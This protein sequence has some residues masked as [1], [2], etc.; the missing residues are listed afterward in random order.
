VVDGC[1]AQPAH[2]EKGTPTAIDGS[3]SDLGYYLGRLWTLLALLDVETHT[4]T[5]GESLRP[6]GLDLRDVH[7]HVGTATVR[8]EEPV[9]LLAVEPFDRAFHVDIVGLRLQPR[10]PQAGLMYASTV[11][12]QADSETA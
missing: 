5:F 11:A 7:E 8:S 1:G 10:L 9:A 3:D 2:V 6:I 12:D 4:L